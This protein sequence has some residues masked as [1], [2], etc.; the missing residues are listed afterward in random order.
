MSAATREPERTGTFTRMRAISA[1]FL[2][3]CL[4]VTLGV[5]V[6]FYI[7]APGVVQ[8]F[9][10]V[11]ARNADNTIIFDRTGEVL[12]TIE[13]TEDRHTVPLSGISPHLQKAVVGIED[14]RFFSHRG[15]D[16]VRLLGAI[17]A[18]VQALAFR[19]GGSTITQQLVKLT[20]LSSERTLA[21][22]IKEIFM[23]LALERTYPKEQI[24]ALYLNQVYFG[25]GIYGVEQAARS[26][27][28]KPAAELSLVE[29]AFLA[30]LIKKPE[31]FLVGARVADEEEPPLLEFAP[32]S[33]V[34]MRQRVVLDNL[35]RLGWIATE[36]HAVA[37]SEPL[38]VYRPAE[39]VTNAPYFVQQVLKEMR[40]AMRVSRV[41]G[42]GF[43]VYTT[44][45]PELQTAAE[46]VVARFGE[47]S[48]SASQGALVA[49]DP[50]SGEVLAL[51]GGVEFAASQFNRA[52]QARRQPGSAFKPILYATAFEQGYGPQT[53]FR[54]EPVRYGREYP[55]GGE[56]IY[57]PH[58]Y[59]ERYGVV[60]DTGKSVLP[61]DPRMTLGRALE[62]SSNVIAVQLLN[63]IGILPVKRLA[64]RL[65]IDV[66]SRMGLCVAL[67][68]SEVTLLEL[69]SAYAT[70]ANGGLRARP[71]FVRRI[72]GSG[73]TV[74]YEHFAEPPEQ[75]VS[76]WT[77][78]QIN[79]LLEGA[80]RRGTGWRARLDRPVGGKT[81]T[82]DGPRDT[83]FIGFTPTLVAGLWSG[84]D[85]NAIM[86]FEAGGRT[87]ASLWRRFM[88]KVLPPYEGESFPTP[89]E[90]YV[91][92]R[93]CTVSGQAAGEWCP[94][95]ET[96]YYLASEAPREVCTVHA[97]PPVA[98]A[99][100]IDSGELISPYCPL[101]SR[102]YR[103]F[104]ANALPSRPCPVHM[105]EGWLMGDAVEIPQL[106]Y[107]RADDGVL[108]RPP[109]D[110]AAHLE[111]A[112]AHE[113]GAPAAPN[114]P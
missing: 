114:T 50:R 41:S 74:H 29:A 84:H 40:E 70:F 78:F 87:T 72:E 58:N 89:D 76:P 53:V 83:W 28:L 61:L 86:P 65:G 57:E 7:W 113:D 60:R 69:T 95:S 27:F 4:T 43:R 68:C 14:R 106:D 81:G 16:P 45:D 62:A 97:G 3:G 24:L 34:L 48:S 37:V 71:V 12:A 13:G 110:Y 32:D 23:A 6:G 55:E 101:D 25:Y 88:D 85:D 22:K 66:R 77:A 105:P 36:E 100:C 17:W 75:V 11:V 9:D 111:Q 18:D 98:H 31:G 19:Q 21:R 1:W 82:N 73:G 42:R 93:T 8:R 99:T 15:M 39:E 112:F 5:V 108:S 2:G 56:E 49:M 59:G 80:V 52:T 54:D 46:E 63:R 33:P 91:A 35:R 10:A 107:V 104:Y 67:G 94:H 64:R 47:G 30:A 102:Q 20:L 92:V 44:L 103:Y 90:P 96:Y 26:Y 38:T 51:V 109:S 79:R